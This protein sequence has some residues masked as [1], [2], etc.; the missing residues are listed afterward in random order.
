MNKSVLK[1]PALWGFLI[2]TLLF[3]TL[4]NSNLPAHANN[5]APTKDTNL[6]TG[7][8]AIPANARSLP[9]TSQQ[10]SP[11]NQI[12]LPLV[13]KNYISPAPLWRFGVSQV[14]RG[15]TSYDSYGIASMRF[16]W[17]INFGV[18]AN[19]ATPYGMEYVPMVRVKQIKTAVD[20]SDTNCRIGPYY[21]TPY[22]YTV[23]P[24]ISQIQSIASTHPG[25][26]WIIGNEMERVDNGSSY[27]DHQDEML[28]ELYAQAY[29]DIYTAIKSSD[30]TAQA[31]IGGM[32]EFTPLR[33][34]YLD[35]VW[36]EYTRLANL[37]ENNWTDKTMPVDV[38]NI[39]L[40]VLPETSCS[41]FPATCWGAEIPAGLSETTGAQ[42]IILDLTDFTKMWDQIVSLR[43]WMKDHGQQ[44][45]PLII[46][47]YSGL[48]PP[49][50]Q[51]PNYPDT[52]GC[53]F[54]PEQVRDNIMYPS[55]DAFLNWTDAGIG[56]SADGNRL[57]QRW[58]WWSL[59][60][61]TGYC[62]DGVY[63]QYTDSLF[64]SGLGPSGPPTDC[65]FPTQ[66]I[67]S[68]G[69]YWI[70]YVQNLPIGSAKPY[71]P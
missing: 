52:S 46:S 43:T 10:T 69:T 29:H 14:R 56:Y 64:Q 31:A 35:R 66:G 39:H 53:P 49:W 2:L 38:W 61:D 50:L 45:K 9:L 68:L 36:A 23:S 41:A 11:T 37:P 60:S 30:P 27:C 57:V 16:G 47:E 48:F 7:A 3:L 12:F 28:P 34:K 13:L 5:S 51:C 15:L 4:S 58:N 32:V 18:S 70:Q 40:Y 22:E 65:P 8:Q 1:S 19:P 63:Y 33:S 6:D 42:Y 25:M 59:D 62:E 21:K 71:A 26:T 20:G 24:S 67:A 55:F 17:Y 44:E 54:T